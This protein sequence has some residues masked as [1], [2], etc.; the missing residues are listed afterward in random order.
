MLLAGVF[1]PAIKEKGKGVLGL[2][3]L[4]GW[5]LL[6]LVLFL[7]QSGEEIKD[8]CIH[9][10]PPLFRSTTG[11]ARSWKPS[12]SHQ[13]ERQGWTWSE[14]V[15]RLTWPLV[16]NPCTFDLQMIHF[17]FFALFFHWLTGVHRQ[18]T[19]KAIH[20]TEFLN[21]TKSRI[22][23][24]T[25]QNSTIMCVVSTPA[26]RLTAWSHVCKLNCTLRE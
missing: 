3:V 4:S 15:V 7:E 20:C 5:Q 21:L 25:A 8:K 23:N 13:R 14:G 22:E 17:K 9:Q 12:T 11:N 6:F 24:S 26:R 1:L 10:Y 19:G 2:K 16:L 18:R